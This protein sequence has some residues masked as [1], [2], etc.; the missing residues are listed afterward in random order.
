MIEFP[1][2]QRQDAISGWGRHDLMTQD[3]C[4]GP[5]TCEAETQKGRTQNLG[6]G[7]SS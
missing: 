3:N 7:G 6:L 5:Q 1:D 2:I 4:L